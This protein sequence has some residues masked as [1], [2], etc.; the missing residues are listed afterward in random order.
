[1]KSSLLSVLFFFSGHSVAGS[2]SV[3]G[4][5]GH[6]FDSHCPEVF[7]PLHRQRRIFL[8]LRVSKSITFNFTDPATSFSY[9]LSKTAI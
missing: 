2:A 4:I 9:L 6:V 5:E 8:L 3:L 1:M 7:D